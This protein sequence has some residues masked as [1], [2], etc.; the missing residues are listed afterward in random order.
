M[1]NFFVSLSFIS[2]IFSFFC[3]CQSRN[4]RF[5]DSWQ[6]VCVYQ[7]RYWDIVR[8]ND[9]LFNPWEPTAEQKKDYSDY[10]QLVDELRSKI[11]KNNAYLKKRDE[12]MSSHGKNMEI[13]YTQTA[14]NMVKKA[15]FDDMEKLLNDVYQE[16]KLSLNQ[17]DFETL[18]NDQQRWRESLQD[19]QKKIINYGYGTIGPLMYADISDFIEYVRLLLLIFIL[20]Q[21]S[22]EQELY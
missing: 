6:Q 15:E 19:Y 12:I 13:A 22:E 7:E 5:Y 9:F 20:E 2:V 3:G 11:R 18:R 17:K 1:K 10:L 8:R 16:L 14:M 21:I 4:D